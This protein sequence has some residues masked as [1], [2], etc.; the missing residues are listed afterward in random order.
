[1]EA[2]D[3]QPLPGVTIVVQGE[4]IVHITNSQENFTVIMCP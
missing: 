3:G 1:M 2:T 4:L